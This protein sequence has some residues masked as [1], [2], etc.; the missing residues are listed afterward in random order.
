MYPFLQNMC[1][2]VYI[3]YHNIHSIPPYPAKKDSVR[4]I[5]DM[6]LCRIGAY[7]ASAI[8]SGRSV[9]DH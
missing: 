2:Q 9:L 4:Q 7:P 6:G 3:Y 5:L 1:I 8:P